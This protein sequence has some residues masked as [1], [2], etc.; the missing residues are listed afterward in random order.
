MELSPLGGK[1]IIRTNTHISNCTDRNQGQ[2]KHWRWEIGRSQE[3]V[4]EVTPMSLKQKWNDQ[5]IRSGGG[6]GGVSILFWITLT[7][8]NYTEDLIFQK[9]PSWKT[10]LYNFGHM[11]EWCWFTGGKNLHQ[12]LEESLIVDK[13]SLWLMIG[14]CVLRSYI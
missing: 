14:L 11:L 8:K 7:L 1:E 5:E 2:S 9:S 4:C 13:N 3:V 6:S 10:Y 12:S